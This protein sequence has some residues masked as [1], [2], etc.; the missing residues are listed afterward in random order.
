MLIYFDSFE[1]WLVFH[2]GELYFYQLLPCEVAESVIVLSERIID[3]WIGEWDCSSS[4][5]NFGN[6]YIVNLHKCK[7]HIKINWL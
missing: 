5:L 6:A 3:F 7:S 1:I 4:H 2:Y